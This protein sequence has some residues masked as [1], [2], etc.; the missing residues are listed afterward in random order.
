M[1]KTYTTSGIKTASVTITSGAYSTTIDCVS[2]TVDDSSIPDSHRPS[3]DSSG[4]SAYSLFAPLV[5]SPSRQENAFY[6]QTVPDDI[7]LQ[8]A[9]EETDSTIEKNIPPEKIRTPLVKLRT[10]VRLTLR[11][12]G[13][14]ALTNE[15]VPAPPRVDNLP[16]FDVISELSGISMNIVNG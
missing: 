13:R 16:L 9:P 3:G 6:Q 15:P 1:S 12:E 7:D 10:Q 11:D 4:N 14:M 5:S 8:S 2:L